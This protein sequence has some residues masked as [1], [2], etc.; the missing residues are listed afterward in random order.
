MIAEQ[1]RRSHR[2]ERIALT[3]L[4][5]SAAFVIAAMGALLLYLSAEGTKT[6]FVDRFSLLTF[7]FSPEFSVENNH[8]G[9]A[10]FV[11]GT[12]AVTLFAIAVG[13]P[14]GVAVGIFLSEIAPYRMTQV[15]KPAIE[16]MV[17]IPSVVY[18]WLG[19]TL[20]VPLIRTHTSSPSGFGLAAA[21]I[22]L[23]IMILPTVITLSED[24]FRSLP[25]ALKEGSLA[26]GATRWQTIT[27][28]LL[29][30]AASGIAV[31]LILGIARAVGEALAIQMVIGNASQFPQGLF[32]PTA[33]LTTEIVTDMPGA[34]AG[35]LL[36]HALF[37]MAFLLLLIA[38]I[39]I[40]FVRFALRKR[41]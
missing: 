19:L 38:M 25:P 23:A 28:V 4:R 8:P 26:L 6:F 24:A 35:T 30:S 21:G 14:F 22:V 1:A 32:A 20:L 9:A 17:G 5:F 16:V 18:G 7:L 10:V 12:L 36:E 31:A 29:P 37:S 41:T 27:R 2:N 15:L 39:L 13:G 34:T 33:T 40:V 11:V 3:A